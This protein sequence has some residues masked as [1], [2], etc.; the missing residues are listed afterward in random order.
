MS[1][2]EETMTA[3]FYAETVNSLFAKCHAASF[4]AGWWH[5]PKNGFCLVPEKDTVPEWTNK[6]AQDVRDAMAPYV[7]ATKFAL[8][9]SEIAE[10]IEGHRKGLPDD[11]L[12]HRTMLETELADAVIRIGD[13]AGALNLDVGGAIVE[14][15]KFNLTRPD[16]QITARR[17][18]GGK[19]Y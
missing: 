10:A 15:M 2:D 4:A 17:D 5:D 16:H 6:A 1:T 19:L 13:F 14:K 3:K 11:K 12:P 7:L 18:P 8:I 9:L